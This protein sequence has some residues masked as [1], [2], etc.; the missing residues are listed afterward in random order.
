M[1]DRPQ[2]TS[3]SAVLIIVTFW[4]PCKTV[5]EVSGCRLH[6]FL[7]KQWALQKKRLKAQHTCLGADSISKCVATVNLPFPW[8]KIKWYHVSLQNDHAYVR[9]IFVSLSVIS[10]SVDRMS[11]KVKVKNISS[12]MG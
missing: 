8:L 2:I 10:Q 12:F 3:D 4:P 1:L 6:S 7:S 5:K 11:H 9:W